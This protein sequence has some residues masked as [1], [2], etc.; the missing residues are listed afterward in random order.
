VPG[1][2]DKA[3]LWSNVL[4]VAGIQFQVVLGLLG[5]RDTIDH[6]HTTWL[7][8]ISDYDCK[9]QPLAVTFARVKRGCPVCDESCL[10]QLIE[11]E[12]TR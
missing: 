6:E 9:L 1:Q 4:I 12:F 2:R 10:H 7:M 11:E 8:N 5:L 3:G